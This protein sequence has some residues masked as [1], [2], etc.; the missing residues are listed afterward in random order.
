MTAISEGSVWVSELLSAVGLARSRAIVKS[1]PVAGAPNRPS[2]RRVSHTR[3]GIKFLGIWSD[4]KN[5]SR[6]SRHSEHAPFTCAGGIN[7]RRG[8]ASSSLLGT[9]GK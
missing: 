2:S 4:M 6:R 5:L 7:L 8:R 1:V 9:Y 3:F